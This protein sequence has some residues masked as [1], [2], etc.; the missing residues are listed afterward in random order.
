[1]TYLLLYMFNCSFINDDL[2]T[3]TCKALVVCR[4]V[5]ERGLN[6]RGERP[7]M[8]VRGDSLCSPLGPLLNSMVDMVDEDDDACNIHS[9]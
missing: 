8:G 2:L 6:W 1:M 9:V 7:V 4:V 3:L 5:G